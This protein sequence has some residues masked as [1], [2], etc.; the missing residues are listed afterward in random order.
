MIWVLGLECWL[1]RL[2]PKRHYGRVTGPLA[3]TARQGLYTVYCEVRAV[4]DTT[5]RCVM[6]L[7][8]LTMMVM[9]WHRVRQHAASVQDLGFKVDEGK[10]MTLTETRKRRVE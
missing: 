2:S 3:S 7:V 10:N 1:A 8:G 4:I 6:V 5:G 9:P